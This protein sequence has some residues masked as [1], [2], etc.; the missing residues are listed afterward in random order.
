MPKITIVY[1][2]FSKLCTKYC[3]SPF[4]EEGRETQCSH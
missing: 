1:L 2:N 4:L 3:W